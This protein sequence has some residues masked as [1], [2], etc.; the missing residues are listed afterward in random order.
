MIIFLLCQKQSSLNKLRL[1]SQP[2]C[3]F[4]VPPSKWTNDLT[5]WLEIAYPEIYT[6]LIELAWSRKPSWSIL[7]SLVATALHSHTKMNTG[8]P[9]P[10]FCTIG[11]KIKCWAACFHDIWRAFALH[12]R[13]RPLF[14]T[15]GD[16]KKMLSNIFHDILRAFALYRRPRFTCVGTKR[17]RTETMVTSR[18][19][20]SPVA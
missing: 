16:K 20:L 11:G 6:Y 15:I 9:R 17:V 2:S 13:R 12:R 10:L 8:E 14:C 4:S 18:I 5:Q 7:T 1:I 3:P 19:L